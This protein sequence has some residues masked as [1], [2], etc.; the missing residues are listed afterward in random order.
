MGPQDPPP[1]PLAANVALATLQCQL[2]S[3]NIC[4]AASHLLHLI[5]TLRLSL[6]LMDEDTVDAEEAD[7]VERT[8]LRTNEA[9]EEAA[10]LEH[11]CSKLQRT[12][13]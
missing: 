2:A 12:L 11:E 8:R 6:L 4:A 7:T 9:L 5:R 10:R 13:F 1:P 3:E